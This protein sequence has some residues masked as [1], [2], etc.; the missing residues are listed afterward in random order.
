MRASFWCRA[1]LPR[2]PCSN[3]M[4]QVWR[5]G[6][7]W[8]VAVK[9]AEERKVQAAKTVGLWRWA[10]GALAMC[11]A[12]LI[13]RRPCPTAASTV[14]RGVCLSSPCLPMRSTDRMTQLSLS[15]RHDCMHR[16]LSSSCGAIRGATSLASQAEWEQAERTRIGMQARVVRVGNAW[17]RSGRS[18]NNPMH[19][20]NGA[21]L[22]AN[23][24]WAEE[25]VRGAEPRSAG[26]SQHDGERARSRSPLLCSVTRE[27]LAAPFFATASEVSPTQPWDAVAQCGDAGRGGESHEDVAHASYAMPRETASAE[28]GGMLEPPISQMTGGAR[29]GWPSTPSP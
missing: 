27:G 8:V 29:L 17:H 13:S 28:H 19:A 10:G 23:A 22:V 4:K 15:F 18:A 20:S 12:G 21:V 7:S 2:A 5:S 1:R 6:L 25:R 16:W 26:Y 14:S 3:N 9:K 24:N 11:S